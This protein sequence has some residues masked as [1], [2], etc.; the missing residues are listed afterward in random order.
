MPM[1]TIPS[2]ASS[3]A[4]APPRSP[5]PSAARGACGRRAPAGSSTRCARATTMPRWPA[6]SRPSRSGPFSPTPRRSTPTSMP[7][8]IRCASAIPKDCCPRTR[9][10]RWN[11]NWRPSMPRFRISGRT[12]SG[13]TRLRWGRTRRS[14]RLPARWAPWKTS[15]WTSCGGST[16]CV[17]SS[18]DGTRPRHRSPLATARFPP[19]RRFTWGRFRRG[20]TTRTSLSIRRPAGG[21]GGR[22]SRAIPMPA[23]WMK[24]RRPPRSHGPATPRR[25]TT[26]AWTRWDRVR[27]R[28][29]AR[30]RGCGRCGE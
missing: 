26:G 12:W 20:T 22:C 11:R 14:G 9:S 18:R 30:C 7:A 19:A 29:S 15:V 5:S 2:G 23:G 1:P 10:P 3:P 28:T 21:S 24:N 6:S 4:R 16:G 17:R 13:G 8:R 27:N 25:R